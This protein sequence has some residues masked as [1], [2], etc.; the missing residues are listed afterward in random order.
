MTLAR[1]ANMRAH[2][3]AAKGQ[4]VVVVAG[5]LHIPAL[6]EGGDAVR[7]KANGSAESYLIAYG[8]EALDAYSGYGAGLRYPGWFDRR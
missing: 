8:E 7:V 1:S 6:V 4:R 3:L 2:L 5:G